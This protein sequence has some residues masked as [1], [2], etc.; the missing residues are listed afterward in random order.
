MT[1]IPFQR[2]ASL[3]QWYV[4]THL[5]GNTQAIPELVFGNPHLS[6]QRFYPDLLRAWSISEVKA[7]RASKARGRSFTHPPEKARSVAQERR[8]KF[9]ACLDKPR[10]QEMFRTRPS[11]K[12]HA[13]SLQEYITHMLW[14][15]LE[16]PPPSYDNKTSL[17]PGFCRGTRRPSPRRPGLALLRRSMETA[18]GL[19][20]RT[21]CVAVGDTLAPR[22]SWEGNLQI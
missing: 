9:L 6:T 13:T 4:R 22:T 1:T 3:R 19:S 16:A 15:I 18:D 10:Q 14:C 5:K 20:S 2:D 12:R 8:Q 11:P 7:T 17:F 21:P